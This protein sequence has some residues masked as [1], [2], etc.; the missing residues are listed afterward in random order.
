MQSASAK[1]DP[2]TTR[3]QKF[4]DQN[5]ISLILILWVGV[6]VAR[7]LLGSS[8]TP[9]AYFFFGLF[10]LISAILAMT[11]IRQLVISKKP[12][13]RAEAVAVLIGLTSLFAQGLVG[14]EASGPLS[15]VALSAKGG[16]LN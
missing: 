14:N 7:V 11:A 9:I 10:W 15:L 5:L 4:C 12:E 8:T 2:T 16:G 3:C 13:Q 6:G 1:I